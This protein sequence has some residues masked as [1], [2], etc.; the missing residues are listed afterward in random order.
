MEFSIKTARPEKQRSACVVFGV[1]E[2]RKPQLAIDALDATAKDFIARIL[3]R[4]DLSGKAGATLLLH[5]VPGMQSE[6]VLLVGLGKEKEFRDK[7]YCAALR[8]V[9]KALRDIGVGEASLFLTTVGVRKQDVAWRIRQ[10]VIIGHESA[11]AFDAFKS[12]QNETKRELALVTLT[13]A[14]RSDVSVAETALT[15]GIAIGQGV[16]LARD[17]G[18]QPGNVCDPTYLAATAIELA[19]QHGIACQV[20]ERSEMEALGMNALLSVAKGSHQPP[21][22]IVLEY[23]GGKK[24]DKAIDKG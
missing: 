11:Y 14:Q 13:V 8:T 20:L 4:G 1:F 21:K 10:A 22:L 12:S 15:Q 5:D 3:E 17:L 19:G 9:Y 6:R 7:A 23:R 2:A 24:S 16:A 18:N